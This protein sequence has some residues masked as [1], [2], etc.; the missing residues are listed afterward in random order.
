MSLQI[1]SWL[2]LR[3]IMTLEIP[4]TGYYNIASL[5]LLFLTAFKG[6]GVV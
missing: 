5:A 1:Y 2:L 3:E 6:N 4:L